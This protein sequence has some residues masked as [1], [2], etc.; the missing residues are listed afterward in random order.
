MSVEQD[1]EAFGGAEGAY[2]GGDVVL[3]GVDFGVE[4]AHFIGGDFSSEGG[5]GGAELRELG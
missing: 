5:Q 3:G 4:V 1:L 2:D